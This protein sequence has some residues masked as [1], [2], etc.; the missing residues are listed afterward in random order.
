MDVDDR[1]ITHMKWLNGGINVIVATVAFG[2]FFYFFNS[3]YAVKSDAYLCRCTEREA[4][5]NSRLSSK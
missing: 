2:L 4:N 1:N 5:N 3:N